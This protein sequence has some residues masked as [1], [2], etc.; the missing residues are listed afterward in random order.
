VS[1]LHAT[2]WSDPI[3]MSLVLLQARSSHF[4]GK[5]ASPN[6]LSCHSAM[7]N[8][9]LSVAFIPSQTNSSLASCEDAEWMSHTLQKQTNL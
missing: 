7:L 6:A 3:N 2:E 9:W 5:F 4:Q 1:S 8:I